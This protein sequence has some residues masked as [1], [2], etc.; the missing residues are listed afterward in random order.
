MDLLAAVALML[1]IEGLAIAIFA[2]SMPELLASIESVDEGQR[3]LI[4]WA[5]IA[6]GAAGYLLVRA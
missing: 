4:G 5:M 2:G 3:R 6:L 1:V